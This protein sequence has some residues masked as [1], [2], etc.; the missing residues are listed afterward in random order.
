MTSFLVLRASRGAGFDEPFDMLT[1]CHERVGRMSMLLEGLA[2]HLDECGADADAAQAARDITRYFDVAGP[3]HHEDEERHLFP[4]LI[5]Q[6][7]PAEVAII[8]KLQREHLAMS[9]QWKT[10]RLDLDQLVQGRWPVNMSTEAFARWATF[11]ALYRDHM[12]TE[13]T[14]VYPAARQLSDDTARAGMGYEMAR[15]RSVPWPRP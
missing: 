9:E 5:S 10:L 4:A 14:Q 8:E 13:E 1:A 7:L 2:R 11:A 15:R 3:A 12:A 6:G